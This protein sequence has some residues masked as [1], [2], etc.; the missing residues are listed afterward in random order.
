[1]LTAY[2]KDLIARNEQGPPVFWEGF[3]KGVAV[4]LRLIDRNAWNQCLLEWPDG[5]VH[6]MHWH[7][8]VKHYKPQVL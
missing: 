7:K 5:N 8:L 3:E 6:R 2:A 4:K 1:M